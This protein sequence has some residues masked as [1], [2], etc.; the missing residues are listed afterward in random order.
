MVLMEPGKLKLLVVMDS[1][2]GVETFVFV[3]KVASGP[4]LPYAMHTTKTRHKPH[5]GWTSCCR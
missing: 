3:Q 1:L 4:C 5:E 2:R